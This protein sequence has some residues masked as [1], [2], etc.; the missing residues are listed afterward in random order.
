MPLIRTDAEGGGV[1]PLGADSTAGSRGRTQST[2]SG[3]GTPGDGGGEAPLGFD[4]TAGSRGRTVSTSVMGGST[5]LGAAPASPDYPQG[6]QQRIS[7]RSSDIGTR[8]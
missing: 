5:T 3:K 1:Q 2:G 4:S 8:R 6:E 7:G